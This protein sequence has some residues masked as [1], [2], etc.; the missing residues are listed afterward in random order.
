[1]ARRVS[2]WRRGIL[3][4]EKSRTSVIRNDGAHKMRLAAKPDY[5]MPTG[6]RI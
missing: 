3:I 6:C 4:E 2:G 5:G 1:M